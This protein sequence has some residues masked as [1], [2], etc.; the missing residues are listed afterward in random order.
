[1]SS[2]KKKNRRTSAKSLSGKIIAKLVLIVA[3]MFL[4]IVMISGW[5][6][7]KS[8]MAITNDKLISVAYENAFIIEKEIENACGQARGFANSLK[9]ISALPPEEQRDAIDYA[10]AG[11]L[12]GDDSFTTVFAYFEQNAIADANGQPYSVHKKDIAYEAIAYLDE[13]GEKTGYVF[14]KHEDAFDNFEKD[15]YVSIRETGEVYVMEPYVYQ[16]QGKDIMMIS[17]IAPIYDAEG[18]FLGVAGC[19]VALQDMQSRQYAATGYKSTHMMA[20]SEDGTILLDSSDASRVGKSASESGYDAVQSD[21]EKLKNMKEG[22]YSNS[23]YILHEKTVNFATGKTGLSI[24]V[25]MKLNSG[26]IW[27][28]YIAIDKSEFDGNIKEDT[29]RLALVVIFFGVLLLTIIYFI[30]RS[31]LAPVKKI[32][33]GAAQL[34]EGNLKIKID[35]NTNDELGRLAKAI[36]HISVIMDNYVNDISRQLSRMAENNMDVKIDQKYIGDF[37]PIQASIEK[38]TDSLN[39]TL[40]QIIISADQVASGSE[41]V[42]SGAQTLSKGAT[43]QEA[44][45]NELAAS[46]DSLAEDVTANADDAQEMN[47]T[48]TEVSERI[49]KC[50]D[51]MKKLIEA[52]TEIRNS[53]AGIEKV[54]RTIEDIA[55]QTNL[56]SLNASVEAERAG[57]TGK[58]FVVV[59]H[60]IRDLA[61]RSAESVKQTTELIEH[62]FRAVRNGAAIAD[63]T[64]KSLSAVVDGAEKITDVANK[65]NVASQNQKMILQDLTKSVDMIEEVV[66]HNTTV[67]QESAGTSTELSQHSKRLHELV[68]KFK[69]K[70]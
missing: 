52:M 39:R 61:T 48:V 33:K 38:I 31:S 20:F 23:N 29:F 19:D 34:E 45:V 37:I 60:E 13:N 44:A 63:D 40:G 17:V 18:E 53:S 62:S 49:G 47:I 30:V 68:Y 50:N 58:G 28:L 14:E 21:A 59:A 9:N 36:N 67:S 16:L 26:N 42:S 12:T 56:L 65:I 25:P 51:E 11:V 46:I 22:K 2:E 5:I 32:M 57:E 69:L 4:L 55:R 41:Q 3:F 27:S 8:L 24:L 43:E 35:V 10:L 66:Q 64:A 54:I 7:M 1:M 6:S 70:N 15:Y